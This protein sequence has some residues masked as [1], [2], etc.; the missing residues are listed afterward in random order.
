MS[1]KDFITKDVYE[2]YAKYFNWMN[3]WKQIKHKIIQKKSRTKSSLTVDS[4]GERKKRKE[5]NIPFK[6]IHW[7]LWKKI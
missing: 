4:S 7:M 1:E 2:F 6:H 3:E 5:V